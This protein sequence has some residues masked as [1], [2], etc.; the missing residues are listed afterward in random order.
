MSKKKNKKKLKTLAEQPKAKRRAWLRL[1]KY[2]VGIPALL[3]IIYCAVIMFVMTQTDDA[4]KDRVVVAY[5]VI[6]TNVVDMVCPDGK[7][8]DGTY[9]QFTFDTGAGN[10]ISRRTLDELRKRG[11]HVTEFLWPSFANSAS[12]ESQFSPMACFV[13][14]P[15]KGRTVE[16]KSKGK[17]KTITTQETT[18]RR[19]FFQIS[20]S[21]NL[22]G[23]DFMNHFYSEFTG[24]R[25]FLLLHHNMPEGYNTKVNLNIRNYYKGGAI[26]LTNGRP[27]WSLPLNGMMHE[28]Y[29]D[30]GCTFDIDGRSVGMFVPYS[31]YNGNQSAVRVISSDIGKTREYGYSALGSCVFSVGEYRICTDVEYRKSPYRSPYA[32]NPLYMHT[33][34]GES[35]DILFDF[36]HHALY[37]KDE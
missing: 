16:I 31:E 11:Y 26:Y 8:P 36:S 6:G 22:L 9:A 2:I 30:T 4:G 29:I 21:S 7:N 12:N 20:G 19:V 27:Y 1:L 3:I 34:D 14:F 18:I 28:F 24:N 5:N 32:V 15:Y 35:F 37:L 10:F 25:K 13:D 17:T 33:V 23:R